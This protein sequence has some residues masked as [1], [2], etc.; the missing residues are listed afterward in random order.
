[1]ARTR[2]KQKGRAESGSYVVMPH[3]ILESEEWAA[4]S[5]FEVKLLLDVYAQYRGANNGDLSAAWTLMKRRGW[6]S[7]DT[8]GRALSGLLE[9]GFLLKTRQGGRHKATLLAVT[10]QSVDACAGKLDV[11]AT[12]VAPGT[13]R[14]NKNL[15]RQ[16]YHIAPGG[17]SNDHAI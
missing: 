17:G 9:S 1:M 4:L 3:A 2:L 8:L 14:K 16:P 10:W 11:S 7:K 13:W 6:N 15:P 5:A 12:K